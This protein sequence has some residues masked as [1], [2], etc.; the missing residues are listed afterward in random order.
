MGASVAAL[1]AVIRELNTQVARLEE[2]LAAGFDQHPDAKVVRSLPGL[3]TVL[4][5]RVLGEFGDGPDRYT[6]AKS[7]QELCGHVT[8]HQGVRQ[9]KGRLGPLCAQPA[10]SRR[11]LPVGLRR[12]HRQPRRPL[13]L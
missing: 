4:G 7:P 8:H 5:A 9:V 13:F 11:V 12:H 2:Q 3:G 1:V 10:V 6:D